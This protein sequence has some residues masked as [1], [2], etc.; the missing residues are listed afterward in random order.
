MGSSISA[1]AAATRRGVSTNPGSVNGSWPRA[2]KRSCT[3]CSAAATSMPGPR[4]VR[5]GA[6]AWTAEPRVIP[7]TFGR[8]TPRPAPRR[9]SPIARSR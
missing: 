1:K 9:G 2:S 4:G 8:R 7:A 5:L 3:A 6:P